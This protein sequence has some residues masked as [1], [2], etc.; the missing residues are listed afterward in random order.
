[1][2]RLPNPQSL[3][4]KILLL[5]VFFGLAVSS[6][7][8]MRQVYLDNLDADNHIRKIS[9]YSPS[10][11]YVAFSRWI[12]FTSDSGHTFI[13]K[14]ITLGNVD[15][16]GYSVNLTFGFGIEGVKAFNQ[17]TIVV[18]GDYGLVPAILYSTNGG[19][20]FT[21]VYHSQFHPLQ[22][23]SG[24]TDMIFPE[25]NSVGYAVDADRVLK[26]TNGG[27]SWSVNRIDAQSYFT[28][29][30]AVDNNNVFAFSR[31]YNFSKIIKTTNGGANWTQVNI[32]AGRINYAFFRTT[33]TGW[34]ATYDDNNNYYIYKT[35]NGGSNWTLLNDLEATPFYSS[36][37][38]FVDDNTGY[39]LT[40]QNTVYKTSNG[41]VLWE[42]LPRDNDYAYLGYSHNDLYFQNN[43]QFW[44]GG[45][46]GFLE[47]TTNSGGDPLPK[48]YFKIDTTGV[49]ASGIVNLVNYSG[50]G[51]SYKWYRND[52][53]VSTSYHATYNHYLFSTYD[54]V[55]LVVSDGIHS[56]SVTKYHAFHPPVIVQSFSPASAATGQ[57]VVITGIN[58][59]DLSSVS[60]GGVAAAGYTV[61]S[62]TT[63]HAIV[64]AGASGEVM[65]ATQ[66]GW[67]SLAGF[68]YIPPPTLSSFNPVSAVAGTPITITG[69]NLGSATL[70]TIGGMPASFTVISSTTI[71][72]TAPSGP[73]GTITVTT[74]GGSASVTGYQSLPTIS[75]F[76]PTQGTHGTI[77]TITGTSLSEATGVSIGGIPA[78]SF[79]VNDPNSITAVVGAG[80]SGVVQVTKASGNSSL[81]GFTWYPPPVITSFAPA[82]GPV[83]TVVTISGSGFDPVPSNNLVYFGAVKATVTGGSATSLTVMVP[84]SATYEPISVISNHLV[85]YSS[86]PFQVT[87]ANGG[88]ITQNSFANATVISTGADNGPMNISLGDFDGDGRIDLAVPHYSN[89][90]N[91]S[92]VLIYRNTSTLTAVSFADPVN[93]S[94]LAY[95]AVGIGDLD[96]DGRPD[97]VVLNNQ[98]IAT[99]LNTSSIGTISFAPSAILPAGNAAQGIAI[100]DIDADGKTD[101]VVNHYPDTRTSIYRNVSEPGAISFAAPVDY[102]VLGGRNTVLTDLD[103]DGKPEIIVPNAVDIY[104]SVL[105]NNSTKT[106]I[107]FAAAQTFTGYTHSYMAAGDMDGDGKT[108]LVTG[109]HNGSSISVLRNSSQG[110]TISFETPALFSASS[111][112]GGIAISDL[113]G[114]G[115]PDIAACLYNY[116][117]TVLKNT[118]IPGT[119]TFAPQVNFAPGANGGEPVLA[120]GDI[121]GDG[122]DD[123]IAISEL[124][125]TIAIHVNEVKPEPFIRTFSPTIGENG[126]VVTIS[127]NNFSGVS[128]VTF[129][130]TAAASFVVNSD[131]SIT[132]VVGAGTSGEVSITNSFGTATLGAFIFGIPPS[133]TGFSPGSGPVGTIVTITGSRFNDVAANNTVFFGGVKADVISATPSSLT[134][135][136]PFGSMY[137][138]IQVVV[139]GLKAYSRLPFITTF[140]GGGPF[141][142]NSFAATIAR[143][144]G[145][146]TGSVSDIDGDKKPDIISVNGAASFGIALNKSISG[147]ISFGPYTPIPFT[148]NPG[149]TVTDDIDGDGRPDLAAISGQ[150][151]ISVLRNTSIPGSPSFAPR[152]DIS[153]GISGSNPFYFAFND[154]DGDGKADLVA[155][156]YSGATL[157]IRRNTGSAGTISFDTG[158]D[159]SLPQYGTGVV[160]S[161]LDGDGR[162]DV[163]STSTANQGFSVFRNTSS[164]GNISFA[165]RVDLG[166]G[167]GSITVAD[168]DN[169]GKPDMIVLAGGKVVAYR[170]TSNAG[171]ISFASGVSHDAASAVLWSLTSDDMDGDGRT[172]IIAT[173]FDLKKLAVFRNISTAGGLA[174]ADGVEY[175]I[176][177]YANRSIA[178]DLDGDARPEL[179]SFHSG[180]SLNILRNQVGGVGPSLI[181]MFPVG[182]VAGETIT[183]TG[184]NLTGATEV[185]FGRTAAT[186]FTVV[187][188]DTIRA[189]L[190]VG[191]TGELLVRT[192]GGTASLNG[193]VYGSAPVISGVYPSLAG[194]GATVAITGANL[195]AVSTLQFG[196]VNASSYSII[197]PS[198]IMAVI[199]AGAAGDLTVT[200]PSGSASYSGFSFVRPPTVSSFTPPHAG[201]GFTVDINGS[202]FSGATAVSFGDVPAN[203]FTIISPTL[204]KATVGNGAS[205]DVRVVTPGGS[206]AKTG[207]IYRATPVVHSF[208]P[209]SASTGTSVVISGWN[210]ASITEVQFGGV[211]ASSFTITSPN[212]ITAT[213]AAGSSGSVSVS[214]SWGTASLAGFNYVGNSP[215]IESVVPSIAS[216]GTTVTITGE[217]LTGTS[218][219]S[220]GGTPAASF[221]VLSSKSIRAVVGG[222]NS[223]EVSV[224]TA[225]GN[226]SLGGFVYTSAPVITSFF[227]NSARPGSELVI[228][229]SNFNV[230]ASANTVFFGNVKATVSAASTS[231]LR[232]TVPPGAVYSTISVT[233]NGLTGYSGSAFFPTFNGPGLIGPTAF[234]QKM[235]SIS[236]AGPTSP[237]LADVDLDGRPDVTIANMGGNNIFASNL[238]VYRNLGSPGTI[239]FAARFA[240]QTN[241]AP[242]K[243]CYADFDG[244]GKLDL[245]AANTVDGNAMTVY[246]NTSTSG[247]LSFGNAIELPGQL[248]GFNATTGDF[249]GDGKPDIA[250]VGAYSNYVGVLRNTSTGN[251]ISF[252]TRVTFSAPNYP[253]QIMAADFDGDGKIDLYVA[254]WTGMIL[255]NTSSIGSISFTIP[256]F[257]SNYPQG[258]T[259]VADFDSDGRPDLAI[260][261]G[262][263][264]NNGPGLTILRNGSS[265]GNLRFEN[266]RS[267]SAGSRPGAITVADMDGNGRPDVIVASSTGNSMSVISNRCSPGIIGFE[268]YVDFPTS[269]PWPGIASGDLDG[270]DKP[271]IVLTNHGSNSVS[272]FRNLQVAGVYNILSGC[273]GGDATIT[274]NLSGASYQWQV[275]EGSGFSNVLNNGNYSGANTATLQLTNIP[276]SWN[277]HE[278]R[279]VVDGNPFGQLSRLSLAPSLT[280]SILIA[281][282]TTVVQGQVSAISST[283]SG[284]GASPS[285][286]W[287]DSTAGHDWQNIPGAN[288]PAVNYSALAT[289]D[290]LR[291]VMTS[292]VA[293]AI[294][295]AVTSNTLLFTV[296]PVTSIDPVPGGRYG[297]RLYPNPASSQITIDTLKL[298]DRWQT[299]EITGVDGRNRMMMANIS[300]QSRVTLNVAHLPSGLYVVVL[301]KKSGE[302]AYLKFVK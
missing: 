293:C 93:L 186:S 150:N 229:G 159:F 71:I 199:G 221:S 165:A 85:G 195:G 67:G 126:T 300:N 154:M 110:G 278:Y 287:Q 174:L 232:V 169:D 238:A 168:L 218:S 72:A 217:N 149:I 160:L 97:L 213:V 92:G 86:S 301:R 164:P 131:T 264:A 275:N 11:G 18:Y 74:P 245:L 70:V 128:S 177:E 20:S 155:A 201:S 260:V 105:K 184:T 231:S 100:G 148:N 219:V 207:F 224:S 212:S 163:I 244:D 233:V 280:P 75:S 167:N 250:Y 90:A 19:N 249:D 119:I 129:G 101:L 62:P 138:P 69:T 115:K 220:F 2:I 28:N 94:S 34:M 8:Q 33:A 180:G 125:R 291:C 133:I 263:A 266:P 7:A 282:N 277:H 112:P 216:A 297:I 95:E 153:T 223:G 39:S 202:D 89:P 209:Q 285:Y 222:G 247:S 136:V 246:R 21:L 143:V 118:S 269:G 130:G 188:P 47:L 25:G 114:D 175:T 23:S 242:Q 113:D 139:N 146:G 157:I 255:R 10:E 253:G 52:T 73:S 88:S 173:Y 116:R 9:F 46:H 98:T 141:D 187:S 147:N 58:F 268:R 234:Y 134:V 56:D 117:M 279:C 198:L 200:A 152:V 225:N 144:D 190:G 29:L 84:V 294:P 227:P 140:P 192:P 259:T 204:I 256:P 251:T 14:Y 121:N 176:Y 57:T 76:T 13:K 257:T 81:A 274:S 53:L 26:T 170:N 241:F 31:E 50:N 295:A 172:D 40:G 248:G 65:V 203:S 196:G 258:A 156:N 296:T 30:E 286:Q 179:V 3:P 16:N 123:V 151:M 63:I 137:E 182:G 228:S 206:G 189:A 109:D 61:I 41:G 51:Y 17:N 185:S 99:F 36:K 102:P 64:G 191:S 91:N 103:G 270:D 48:A 214:N 22:L 49:L 158:I 237:T 27:L 5:I 132:A 230:T 226:A 60:F 290:R 243:N 108:D 42:P 239:S 135:S 298:S 283:I 66:T 161:D 302:M 272:F 120:L 104:F 35:T 24:I 107:S 271:D 43:I 193:F 96:G 211:A 124:P 55:K 145:G 78:L 235:D 83:G 208:F 77:M 122:K 59:Y 54:S 111:L 87:F 79:T 181:S 267:F 299:I 252:A 284:G 240:R 44:A 82:S 4:G 32:P 236:I 205:G 12:G 142:A 6:K 262:G 276:S 171:A 273:P 289:G 210:L 37:M 288:S 68:T 261:N 292:S 38:R 1:M 127:G 197:S 166:I 106:N 281:G 162:P 45:G 178:A 194:P 215:A 15:F 265:P 183:I 80:S 254:G